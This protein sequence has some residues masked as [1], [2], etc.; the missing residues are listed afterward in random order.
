MSSTQE[1]PVVLRPSEALA[2]GRIEVCLLRYDNCC[3]LC[4]ASAARDACPQC[5]GTGQEL[6]A[7][8][9]LLEIPAGVLSCRGFPGVD[10]PRQGHFS[11]SRMVV[12]DLRLTLW[13]AME[14]EIIGEE[15]G[16]RVLLSIEWPD[17]VITA[18]ID[19]DCAL[20]AVSIRLPWNG[21]EL[22]SVPRETPE[23]EWM[24]E[25]GAGLY[26]LG[27]DDTLETLPEKARGD[28]VL[29]VGRG[30]EAVASAGPDQ[31]ALDTEAWA[32]AAVAAAETG[33]SWV[34]LSRAVVAAAAPVAGQRSMRAL[35]ISRGAALSVV[36]AIT[37]PPLDAD[38]A[39]ESLAEDLRRALTARN[40]SEYS[41]GVDVG[42]GAKLLE[43]HARVAGAHP[44]VRVRYGAF[45]ALASVTRDPSGAGE[46]VAAAVD[47]LLGARET[48]PEAEAVESDLLAALGM[49]GRRG[50]ARYWL[51]DGLG[52]RR[53]AAA[54]AALGAALAVDDLAAGVR[55]SLSRVGAE[56]N[57]ELM[58]I[59]LWT[60]FWLTD[61][62]AANAHH[63]AD[64]ARVT[65]FVERM[66]RARRRLAG[67]LVDGAGR[68]AADRLV[69]AAGALRAQLADQMAVPAPEGSLA[70]ERRLAGQRLVTAFADAAMG[71][72]ATG[73]PDFHRTLL[74]T[75]RGG[76]ATVAGVGSVASA[77]WCWGSSCAPRVLAALSAP[78]AARREGDPQAT[79]AEARALDEMLEAI[80]ADE[81]LLYRAVFGVWGAAHENGA[82]LPQ[83]DP[84]VGSL[85]AR[86]A[87][88][89]VALAHLCA[90]RARLDLVEGGTNPARW[91]LMRGIEYAQSVLQSQ[92]QLRILKQHEPSLVAHATTA[93]VANTALIKREWELRPEPGP[94]EKR[95]V[96]NTFYASAQGIIPEATQFHVN[97]YEGLDQLAQRLAP[98]LPHLFENS[99][100][101]VREFLVD[102]SHGWFWLTN[103]RLLLRVR[104]G[105]HIQYLPLQSITSYRVMADAV[106]T[107]TISVSLT[108]GT[109]INFNSIPNRHLPNESLVAYVMGLRHW[110]DLPQAERAALRVGGKLSPSS[111]ES[112]E[113]TMLP[114]SAPPGGLQALPGPP[115]S[116][117]GALPGPSKRAELPEG[118]AED[119]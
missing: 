14:P 116:A 34:A 103:Y 2:G 48:Q 71:T 74:R 44:W 92:A 50:Y 1:W 91:W 54:A 78:T 77:W 5:L 11:W 113:R 63:L 67:S 79:E 83:L 30:G 18:E 68:E 89:A 26:V 119:G 55:A 104:D 66:S 107:S 53:P 25:R 49:L 81:L 27:S 36:E 112:A 86:K 110:E 105:G 46:S 57:P 29:R 72:G 40:S 12:G 4:R 43:G 101:M 117:A 115:R 82:D 65:G 60:L 28:L 42:A 16:A 45:S 23:G 64:H 3:R 84:L 61:L 31:A 80:E 90:W 102:T 24:R 37:A 106:T 58:R 93:I 15:P 10:Y 99:E 95:F 47:A 17:I 100:P 21:M 56:G 69:D 22:P 98:E 114:A 7:H 87:R 62:L 73:S 76:A 32:R 38:A 20:D 8:D 33:H 75:I 9:L 109:T 13:P 70:A 118:E 41:L 85:E 88:T 39:L 35:Q 96:D 59:S 52:G 19:G 94:A 6:S 108:D 111:R 97:P 51:T